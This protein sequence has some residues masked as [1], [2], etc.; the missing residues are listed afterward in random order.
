MSE[1]AGRANQC[2]S[3]FLRREAAK[4]SL[5]RPVNTTPALTIKPAVHQ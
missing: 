3:A 5:V 2:D 4:R 1:P